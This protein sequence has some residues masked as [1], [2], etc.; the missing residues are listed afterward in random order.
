MDERF[1]RLRVLVVEDHE[2]QRMMLERTL[3]TL[4]AGT[5]RG[6]AN[7]VQATSMLREPGTRFDIVITDLMMP[8]VDGIELIPIVGR[9][10]AGA[11]LVLSSADEAR[12]LAAAEIAKAHR[13]P[14]LGVLP[15]PITPDTLRPLLDRYLADSATPDG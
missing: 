4:G 2:F 14:V 1:N 10:A 9:E 11:S 7:G 13:V 8:D 6:A 15:K 3:R 5:V 12:L